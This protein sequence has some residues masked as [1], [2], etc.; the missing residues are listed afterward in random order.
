MI[1]MSIRYS[2][3][4]TCKGLQATLLKQL[5]LVSS[6]L[7]TVLRCAMSK[8]DVL[9]PNIASLDIMSKNGFCHT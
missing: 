2:M 5:A 3:Y 6:C 1:L 9:T 8:F 4:P 7:V